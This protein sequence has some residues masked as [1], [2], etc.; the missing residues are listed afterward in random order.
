MKRL[1]SYLAAITAVASFSGTLRAAPEGGWALLPLQL[2]YELCVHSAH[3]STQETIHVRCA[4]DRE[5]VIAEG[6]KIIGHF[7]PTDQLDARRELEL[8]LVRSE[9]LAARL[10]RSNKTYRPE[11]INYMACLADTAMSD[12]MYLQGKHLD[13]RLIAEKCRSLYEN[14]FTNPD[15]SH[16]GRDAKDRMALL[17]TFF[18]TMYATPASGFGV[19][20]PGFEVQ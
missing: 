9:R 15:N 18:K 4:N 2:K 5:Q 1:C 7:Y 3:E 10:S 6:T 17:N 16:G 11:V 12:P 14:V 8:A 19:P 13:G 20:P